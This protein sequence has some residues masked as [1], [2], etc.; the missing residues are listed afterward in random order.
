M[1]RSLLSERELIDRYVRSMMK[2]WLLH[3]APSP[4]VLHLQRSSL[5]QLRS[6]L[7]LGKWRWGWQENWVYH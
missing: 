1:D 4:L 7:Q 3:Q 2:T 6:L 5:L